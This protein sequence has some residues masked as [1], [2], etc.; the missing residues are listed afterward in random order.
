MCEKR[1]KKSACFRLVFSSSTERELLVATRGRYGAQRSTLIPQYRTIIK[2]NLGQTKLFMA[3]QQKEYLNV[4]EQVR[5]GSYCTGFTGVYKLGNL[6]SFKTSF[7]SLGLRI[8][9]TVFELTS[10]L[11][12]RNFTQSRLLLCECEQKSL[13][14]EVL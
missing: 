10:T 3:P 7:G 13:C 5:Y 4:L 11:T 1:A 9:N 6:V 2:K 12:R 8:P 14:S